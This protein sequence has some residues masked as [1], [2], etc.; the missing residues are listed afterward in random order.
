M[1]ITTPPAE[2]DAAAILANVAAIAPLL[3]EHAAEVEA[4]RRLTPPV[5]DALRGTGVFRMSM[6]KAWGGPELDILTQIDV[7]EALSRADGS[8]GWCAMIGSDSGFYSGFLDDEV[9]RA[10]YP[11]LDSVTAGWAVPAGKLEVCDG[12]YRLSGRWSFGSGC[13]HADVI[14]GGC[15]VNEDGVPRRNEAGIPEWRVAML[16]AERWQVLDTWDTVGLA[17]SGSN[18]YTIT[19]A[20]V[21]VDQTWAPGVPRRD[22][23][24]YA[25]PG[26]FVVNLLG[27]PLGVAGQACDTAAAILAEKVS[28]PHTT[29]VSL[30]PRVRTG[31]AQ[32]RAAVG[33]ARAYVHDTVGR[34]WATVEAGDP[35]S[36]DLRAELVG[37][38]VHTI[39]TCRDAVQQLVHT[40]GTIAAQRSNPLQRQLRDLTMMTVHMTGQTRMWEWSGGLW[41]GEAP[42]MPLF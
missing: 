6:P 16:P 21:P 19:D 8:A 33:S 39:T 9:G 36:T 38:Y 2:L 3:R 15:L 25:W 13:T 41:F 30:E 17:G 34:L 5:I 20:F 29:P 32:A 42:P 12:G 4:A 22:G 14:V 23:A 31:L 35:P 27:V 10:L 28:F 24:L 18:D 26:M 7:I 11:R 1:T 40:T 37:C